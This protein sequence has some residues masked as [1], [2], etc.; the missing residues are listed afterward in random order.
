MGFNVCDALETTESGI[1]IQWWNYMLGKCTISDIINEYKAHGF[2]V[3][4]DLPGHFYWEQ[5]FEE[6]PDAKIWNRTLL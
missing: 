5:L 2:E 3:N 6:C 4:Q 1:S